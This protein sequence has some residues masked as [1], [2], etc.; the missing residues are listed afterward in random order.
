M[1]SSA[2]AAPVAHGASAMPASNADMLQRNARRRQPVAAPLR[3]DTIT[4]GTLA[5]AELS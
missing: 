5:C 2:N 1:A 4:S 3:F